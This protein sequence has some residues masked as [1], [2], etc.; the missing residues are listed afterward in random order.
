MRYL[1]YETKNHLWLILEY[2]VGGDLLALLRQVS[3]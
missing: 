3:V 1:R 2:C